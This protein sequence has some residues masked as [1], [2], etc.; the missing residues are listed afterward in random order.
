[1]PQEEGRPER[2]KL[3]SHTVGLPGFRRSPG[4]S[5]LRHPSPHHHL[6]FSGMQDKDRVGGLGWSCLCHCSGATRGQESRVAGSR[7]QGHWCEA[8]KG[9][10]R[11]QAL[12]SVAPCSTHTAAGTRYW[13]HG[14]CTKPARDSPVREGLC[15]V[16]VPGQEA[17]E[18]NSWD[19]EGLRVHA[20]HSPRPAPHP[21][22]GARLD[23]CPQLRDF[24]AAV[25]LV[26]LGLIFPFQSWV[27]A[28]PLNK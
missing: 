17:Q 4:D 8:P 12:S 16:A 6:E 24:S 9:Q 26:D 11:P 10:P 19:A 18:V 21:C 5:W 23:E 25:A 27:C 13:R 20:A 3:R 15:G 22:R 14:G 1:M 28:F 7:A 2:D